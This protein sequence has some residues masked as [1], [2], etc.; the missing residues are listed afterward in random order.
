MVSNKRALAA[1]IVTASVTVMIQTMFE[2][3]RLNNIK[4]SIEEW[5]KDAMEPEFGEVFD[6]GWNAAL[7]DRYAVKAAYDKLTINN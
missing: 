2:I 6:I 1:V 3:R 5:V 4:P 7:A